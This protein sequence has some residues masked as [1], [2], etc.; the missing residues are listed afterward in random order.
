MARRE[1]E[2]DSDV[3]LDL[4]SD[5]FTHKEMAEQLGCSR[6]T[7][8][9]KI[10]RLQKE[11]PVL[12]NYRTLQTLELTELQHKILSAI[13]DDKI[14]SAPLRDLVLA[15]KIL[16]EKEFMVEGKPQEIKGLVHYLIEIERLEQEEKAG[17]RRELLSDNNDVEDAEIIAEEEEEAEEE[18]IAGCKL[19]EIP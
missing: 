9:K 17:R 19:S 1:F 16:K 15:Y 18:L 12:L 2:V 14:D 10:A 7:L 5:G 6:P 3:L 4:I 11:S 8:E 13:T